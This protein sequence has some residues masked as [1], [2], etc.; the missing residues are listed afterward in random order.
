MAHIFFLSDL[1]NGNASIARIKGLILKD[2]PQARIIDINHEIQ[3]YDVPDGGFILRNTLQ[4][5]PEKAIIITYVDC[6]YK[7][8]AEYILAYANKRFFL[9][10]DNGIIPLSLGREEIEVYKLG[11]SEYGN[12]PGRI[13]AEACAKLTLGFPY[14]QLGERYKDYT[15]I[16]P[17]SPIVK[18]DSI[19][20]TIKKIDRY[21]N[22]I[23]NL[24]KETFERARNNRR[25]AIHYQHH[26]P[27]TFISGQYAEV[28]VGGVLARFNSMDLLEIAINQERA[29]DYLNLKLNDLIKI[30][31]Y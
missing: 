3:E 20:A 2:N 26:N 23:L 31:F 5:L 25:I 9:A 16:F 4:D 27:I 30:D 6:Y 1:G 18:N 29:I 19:R 10:P 17:M 14:R 21:G 8:P 22:L 15:E 12:W 7:D 11:N 24:K 28:E 13:F